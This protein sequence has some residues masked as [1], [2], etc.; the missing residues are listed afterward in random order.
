[1]IELEK[2]QKAPLILYVSVSIDFGY[3][4]HLRIMKHI[5]HRDAFF[6]SVFPQTKIDGV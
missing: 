1:M 2:V 6:V 5:H 4:P 3:L